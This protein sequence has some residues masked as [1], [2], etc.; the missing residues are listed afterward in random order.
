MSRYNFKQNTDDDLGMQKNFILEGD[1]RK[2]FRKWDNVKYVSEKL[3]EKRAPKKSY[4]NKNWGI[5]VKT[6][7]RLDPQNGVGLRFGII[8][9]MKEMYGVNRIDEFIRNCNL[10]GWLVNKI[11]VENRIDI[12]KKVNEEIEFI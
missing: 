6:N 3:K 7:N 12:H 1:A 9:T 5:E 4:Q 11:D 8:V 10:N 2:S